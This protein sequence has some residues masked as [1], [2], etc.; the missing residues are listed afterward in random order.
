MQNGW[1]CKLFEFQVVHEKVAKATPNE[2][3]VRFHLRH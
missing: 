1:R 3:Q 2:E